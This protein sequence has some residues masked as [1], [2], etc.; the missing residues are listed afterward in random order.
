MIAKLFG[1]IAEK[2]PDHLVVDV[3]GVGYRV[4]I[5]A[6]TFYK[7]GDQGSEVEL[8]IYTNVRDDAI[9]LFG[10]HSSFERRMFN[11][12]IS[13][14]GIGPKLAQNIL[15]G[16]E[17][18]ALAEAIAR[19]AL[20]ELTRIPGLGKK[21]AQR[22]LVE[23]RDKVSE[24]AAE[25]DKDVAAPLVAFDQDDNDVLS[26]MTNLGYPSHLAEQALSKVKKVKP[27]VSGVEALLR[28]T[29]KTLSKV[30]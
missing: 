13:V 19:G 10:F 9:Q 24:L 12:L 18:P 21:I 15:S 30:K 11:Y 2:H 6:A 27:D 22:L 5:S 25:T 1:I 29:L 7:L 20:A 23:L 26:A 4:F 17:A 14:S 28:E 16:M 8:S 3:N